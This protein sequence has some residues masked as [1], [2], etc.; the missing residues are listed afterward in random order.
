MSD[1]H[2]NWE[3]LIELVTETRYGKIEEMTFEN[4]IPVN[5]KTV[6]Q[7]IKLSVPSRE[8]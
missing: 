4:G 2:P 7:N 3:R 6:V 1:L 5:C 8:K